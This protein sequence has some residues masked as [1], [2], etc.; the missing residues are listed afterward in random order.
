M[1]CSVKQQRVSRER[2]DGQS[3][4]VGNKGHNPD[5]DSLLFKYMMGMKCTTVNKTAVIP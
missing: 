2:Y 1:N 3:E 4:M 5:P